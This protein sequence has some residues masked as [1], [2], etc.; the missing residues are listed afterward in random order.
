ML[1]LLSFPSV[2]F[3]GADLRVLEN[4]TYSFRCPSC[5]RTA[6]VDFSWIVREEDHKVDL[7][8]DIAEQTGELFGDKL[9]TFSEP[10]KCP[11]C[12]KTFIIHARVDETSYNAFRV[13][14]LGVAEVE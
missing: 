1:K 8:A 9:H 4:T 11:S 10:A 5:S 2:N 13:K 14:I 12:E 6:E 7:D 3:S